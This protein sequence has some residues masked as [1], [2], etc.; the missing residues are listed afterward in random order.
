MTGSSGKTSTKDLLAA[1]AGA[2][3][4]RRSRRRGRSTTSSAT[5]TRCCAPTR[6]PATWCWR[7][8]PAASGTSRYLTRIAPPRIGVVLNVGT[9]H[10]GE[11]GSPGGRSRRPRASWSRRCP[12]DG[13]A[14]LNADDPLVA[15]DG[16]PAPRRGWSPVGAAPAADVRAVGR[17]RSTSGPRRVQL[18]H[19]GRRRRRS[20]WRARRAPGRQRPG[21][22]G[23]RAG[24]RACRCRGGR[25]AGRGRALSPRGGWRSPSA[26]DGVTVINDAYNAN[27][28]SMRA[29]LRALA[30]D[31]RAGRRVLGGARRDGRAGRGRGARSTDA[32]GALAAELGV[33]RLVVVGARRRGRCTTAPR[34]EGSL[35]R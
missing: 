11:F 21:R 20:R 8:A 27:P 2:R 1:A 18:V 12:P 29:A 16:R 17:D 4:A 14:V 7:W 26:P 24:A 19:R 9:A 33:D 32:I 22:R 34:V 15:G 25:G 28:E 35:G 30:D 13:V 31:G 5:R 6:T 23:G 3:S 10:L